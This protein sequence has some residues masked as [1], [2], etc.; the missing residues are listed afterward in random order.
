[1]QFDKTHHRWILFQPVFSSPFA[2]CF[3]ISTSPD[4]TGTYYRYSFPQN[5]GFPDYPKLGIMPDAIYQ[6][7]NIFN[8]AGTAYLGAQPCAYNLTKMLVGD[9]TAE[10]ICTLDNSN[11]TLFDDSMLPADLD[12]PEL[13]L[14]A[15]TPEVFV[16]SIDNNASETN[17]YEYTYKRTLRPVP[18]FSPVLAGPLPIATGLAGLRGSVQLRFERLHSAARRYHEYQ[19]LGLAGRSPD[20]PPGS[21]P[22][23]NT[24]MSRLIMVVNHAI[25]NGSTG[26]ER[27][28][29]FR[30]PNNNLTGSVD[31]SGRYLRTGCHLSLHGLACH[32]QEWRHRAGL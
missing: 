23:V 8:A 17:I 6:S 16:G 10:Q 31:L 21:P 27:W 14:P 2:S 22:D 7:Q 5:A 29:E 12:S 4:A 19:R 9:T 18:P 3:A 25:V 13:P 15:G 20:V 28:Y 32:G 1:M 11:G 24:R 30:S 26:A